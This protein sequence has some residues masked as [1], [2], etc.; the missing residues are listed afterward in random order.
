MNSPEFAPGGSPAAGPEAQCHLKLSRWSC[1]VAAAG[2][3]P[4]TEAVAYIRIEE[5]T[6]GLSL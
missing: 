1:D 4:I 5:S 6:F 2:Y 3:F